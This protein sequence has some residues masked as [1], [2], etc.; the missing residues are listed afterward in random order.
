MVERIA[1]QVRQRR[2][3]LLQDVP[4]HR[5]VRA[6]NLETDLLLQ[7][8][9]EITDQPGKAVHAVGKGLHA[10]GHNFVVE[11]VGQFLQSS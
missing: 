6:Q 2:F 8:P 4:I 5:C 3:K 11:P 9:G 7:F 10:A 1:N